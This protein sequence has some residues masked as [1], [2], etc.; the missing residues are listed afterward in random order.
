MQGPEEEDNPR[1]EIERLELKQSYVFFVYLNDQFLIS[2]NLKFIKPHIFL[3]FD[4][5][6]FTDSYWARTLLVWI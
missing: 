4:Y 3:L 6:K 5:F 2:Q 1:K